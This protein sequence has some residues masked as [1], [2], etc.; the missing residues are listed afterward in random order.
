MKHLNKKW[1]LLISIVLGVGVGWYGLKHRWK[2]PELPYKAPNLA[3][4]NQDP[5]ERTKYEEYEAILE[6]KQKGDNKPKK[7]RVRFGLAKLFKPQTASKQPTPVVSPTSTKKPSTTHKQPSK[8][9][10]EPTYFFAYQG[11]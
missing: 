6:N 11:E 4:I 10:S 3:P 7:S 2:E 8:K 5:I 9:P 1:I